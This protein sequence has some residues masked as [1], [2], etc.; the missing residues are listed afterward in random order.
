MN[1]SELETAVVEFVNRPNYKPVKPRVIAKRLGLEEQ[2]AAQMKRAVKQ[3]VK[4][5]R[6]AYGQN[7]LLLP[8]TTAARQLNEEPERTGKQ[9]R[10]EFSAQRVTGIFRRMSAG[11]GFV[12]PSGA[13]AGDRSGDI[14]VAAN[15]AKDA[16]SGDIVLVALSRK[17]DIRRQNPEGEIVEILERETH[18]FVGT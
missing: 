5:G 9:T 3:L 8:V 7:H 14:F 1:L 10:S 11:Y 17:R 2:A 6:I 15:H 12:R 18:Q 16:A 4:T 13:T